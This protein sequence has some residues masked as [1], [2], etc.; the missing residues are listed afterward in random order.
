MAT[1]RTIVGVPVR[2]ADRSELVAALA[3]PAGGEGS[4]L[5][6]GMLIREVGTGETLVLDVDD[7]DPGLRD[8]FEA[9]SPYSTM[10]PDDFDAVDEHT[11]CL[12]LVDD[13]GGSIEAAQRMVRF[14]DGILARGGIAAK[15]ESAGKAHSRADWAAFAADVDD[16]SRLVDAFMVLVGGGP[17]N[18]A[19]T[20]GMHNLGLPDVETS[21][22]ADLAATGNLL[23][24]FCQYLANDDP[25][26]ETGHTFSLS[27]DPPWY[28]LELGPC[29]R[30]APDD[31]F[32]NPFG[33][34][35]LHPTDPR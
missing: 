3:T 13:G 11:M 25:V 16:I 26:L 5:A 15:V 9:A 28:E 4:F 31:A 34:W 30:F 22:A 12:Y 14:V 24:T 7:R 2:Y 27:P 21:D 8:A 35:R 19:Y 10:T 20:C 23:W 29:T 33:V 1:A 18:D 6:A 32:H 17:G